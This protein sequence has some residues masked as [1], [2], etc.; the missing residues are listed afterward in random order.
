MRLSYQTPCELQGT[1]KLKK[2]VSGLGCYTDV[3]GCQWDIHGIKGNYV[4]ATRMDS[5]HPYYTD[6]SS[7]DHFAIDGTTGMGGV[8]SQSWEPWLVEVVEE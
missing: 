4:Q 6:T 8:V 5:L 3:D 7:T 1:I 2:R